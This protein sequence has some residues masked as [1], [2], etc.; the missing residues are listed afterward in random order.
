MRV[1]VAN[2]YTY[3]SEL[4]SDANRWSVP[5]SVEDVTRDL[6]QLV[7]ETYVRG[8]LAEEL[9]WNMDQLDVEIAPSWSAEPMVKAVEVTLTTGSNGDRHR[10]S[11][12]FDRGPWVRSAEHSVQKMRTEGALTENEQVYRL[13]AAL[14]DGNTSKPLVPPT[15][16]PPSIVDQP[17]SELGIAR[18]GDGSLEP[19]RPVLVSKRLVEE[20]ITQC[21]SSGPTETGGAA[22]GKN[23]RL[24]KP[25]PGTRTRIVTVLTAMVDDPRHTGD[26]TRFH[27]SPEA[28]IAAD[29]IAALRGRGEFVI[30]IVHTHG[31]GC[32]DC[33][34]KACLLAECFPSLQDYELESLFPTKALLLPIAGRMHGAPGQRP[35]LQIHAWRGGELRPI[36]WQ[37]YYD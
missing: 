37:T 31:W 17:L 24:L 2:A 15:L 19:D 10:V 5:L 28:L 4:H 22:L 14:N 12:T 6:G 29:Q 9:P 36:R 35:I 18:L 3:Y 27:I 26:L 23:V 20:V 33:N 21:E 13:L 11:L 30:T 16:V 7:E 25:L 34:Q 8:L 32:G 1:N